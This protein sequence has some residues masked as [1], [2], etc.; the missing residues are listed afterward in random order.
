MNTGKPFILS[1]QLKLKKNIVFKSANKDSSIMIQID[2]IWIDK[3]KILLV[4]VCQ[5]GLVECSQFC[6]VINWKWNFVFFKPR[7]V[8]ALT[9]HVPMNKPCVTITILSMLFLV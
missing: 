3:I 4:Q 6:F 2:P 9:K 8:W 1:F 5:C 7:N